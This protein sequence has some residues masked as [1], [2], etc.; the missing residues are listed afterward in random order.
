MRA[1]TLLSNA[2]LNMPIK[3]VAVSLMKT[4][5]SESTKH[6]SLEEKETAKENTDK[7][8]GND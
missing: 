5:P 2:R 6:E 8:L 7:S 4:D 1:V 3:L